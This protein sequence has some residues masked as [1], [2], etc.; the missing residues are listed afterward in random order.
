M[1]KRTLESWHQLQQE[2]KIGDVVTG[3]VFQVEAYGSYVDI[4]KDFYGIVLAPHI[5]D[6]PGL[7]FHEYPQVG[8]TISSRILDFSEYTNPDQ[9]PFNYISL[10][11]KHL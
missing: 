8:E 10:S 3:T 5:S 2:L 9:I 6:K 4:G 1:N 7:E 11:I